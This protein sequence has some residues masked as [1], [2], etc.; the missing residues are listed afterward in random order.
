MPLP[1]YGTGQPGYAWQPSTGNYLNS[2]QP[3]TTNQPWPNNWQQPQ[4]QQQQIS[5][6]VLSIAPASSRENAQ[7][8]PVA[9]NTDLYLLNRREMKLYF[10]CNP[11]NPLEMEEYDLVKV[12]KAPEPSDVVTRAEVDELKTMM[13]QMLSMIQGNNQQ[14]GKHRSRNNGKRGNQDDRSESFSADDQ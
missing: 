8:F 4:T 13:G 11:A 7:Q 3:Q 6:R 5:S 2:G 14:G 9:V 10:K 12:E 1:N